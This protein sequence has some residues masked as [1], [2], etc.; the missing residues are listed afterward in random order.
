MKILLD[1]SA[2]VGFKRNNAELVE[3]ITGADLILFSSVVLGE[4]LFG[5]RN[6]TRFK[7]NLSDLNR[8]LAHDAVETVSA[9][10]I[11]ADRY[12]RIAAQLK[13][14]GT[15]IP[16]NDIW[17]AAQTME[18]GAELITIDAHFEKISGLVYSRLP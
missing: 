17:I 16:T 2:Y 11:T 9:G 10:K 12:S 5:F 4:L 1:T 15:P 7:K 14:Q 13:R 3:T 8:F 6:G 18:Y